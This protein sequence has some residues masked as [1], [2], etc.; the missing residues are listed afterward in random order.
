LISTLGF[1][2]PYQSRVPFAFSPYSPLSSYSIHIP[3]NPNWFDISLKFSSY[4][5]SNTCNPY[6]ICFYQ[7]GAPYPPG[8]GQ[9]PIADFNMMGT[10]PDW[11]VN[12]YGYYLALNFGSPGSAALLSALGSN[13][14]YSVFFVFNDVDVEIDALIEISWLSNGPSNVTFSN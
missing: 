2:S 3:P 11:S 6:G 7:F 5:S 13:T 1:P 12:T 9:A 10:A 8:P 14:S 4:T